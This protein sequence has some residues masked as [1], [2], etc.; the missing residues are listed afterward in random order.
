MC[1][2]SMLLAFA[3]ASAHG[4]S[5]LPL[6][7]VIEAGPEQRFGHD[8]S[9]VLVPGFWARAGSDVTVSIVERSSTLLQMAVPVTIPGESLDRPPDDGVDFTGSPGSGSITVS[10]GHGVA[11]PN[12]ATYYAVTG[13]GVE[14]EG[15]NPCLVTLWGR[16]VDPTFASG[17]DRKLAQVELEKCRPAVNPFVDFKLASTAPSQFIRRL[18]VCGGRANKILIPQEAYHSTSWEIKGLRVEASRIEPTT[19]AVEPLSSAGGFIR[20]NCSDAEADDAMGPGWKPWD[21]CPTGQLLTGVTMYHF[22]EKYFTG[23][24]AL[25][26][27]PQRSSAPPPRRDSIGF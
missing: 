22:E 21:T 8:R 4:E 1:C 25:C 7:D 14:E 12:P 9:V 6:D 19:D 11:L 5:R 23:I 20:T 24:G 18:R 15:N 26:R 3:A 2:S 10:I 17:G 16:L 13:I 27:Q